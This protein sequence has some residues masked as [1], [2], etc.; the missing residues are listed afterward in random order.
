MYAGPEDV[1]IKKDIS[2]VVEACSNVS[3]EFPLTWC[4]LLPGSFNGVPI[5][6][7]YILLDTK[8]SN[9]FYTNLLQGN[10][11]TFCLDVKINEMNRVLIEQTKSSQKIPIRL[12]EYQSRGST[13]ILD[14]GDY[15]VV[16]CTRRDVTLRRLKDQTHLPSGRHYKHNT[17]RD[18]IDLLNLIFDPIE[19]NVMYEPFVLNFQQDAIQIGD[20]CVHCYNVDFRVRLKKS[21]CNVGIEVKKDIA[22]WAWK[23]EEALFKIRKYE[24]VMG[25]PCLLLV[26]EPEAAFYGV[27][28]S[29]LESFHTFD[30][31]KEY[32]KQISFQVL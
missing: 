23:K 26:M 4:K 7:K 3:K 14:C 25:A 30:Q 8:R 10:T 32:M 16:S 9:G 6:T 20:A 21:S 27:G 17:E 2:G 1:W 12:A 31:V 18:A 15:H 5:V 19:F 13:I 28:D 11:A 29:E 24:Q 22:A